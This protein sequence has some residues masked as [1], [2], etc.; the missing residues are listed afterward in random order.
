MFKKLEKLNIKLEENK[1]E[2]FKNYIELFY[3][4][5]SK[6]NLISKNDEN[7]LFEKH[8]FDSLAINLFLEKY[9][10]KQDI[11]ILDIGTGGG[12]PSLPISL[13]FE[14]IHTTALD[15]IKK[16]I[17]TV[18]QRIQKQKN[19]NIFQQYLQKII[20]VNLKVTNLHFLLQEI[21]HM[22]T[23]KLFFQN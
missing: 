2:L 6:I 4:Y 10:L 18:L 17:T 23:E 3:E 11:N 16:K 13:A 8:I 21:Q 20:N 9:K 22:K 14:N 19:S 15:S 5:N 7:V 1:K 12:F